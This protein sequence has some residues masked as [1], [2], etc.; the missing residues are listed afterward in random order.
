MISVWGYVIV[1]IVGYIM[2]AINE[3]YRNKKGGDNE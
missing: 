1:F 3:N 2:G